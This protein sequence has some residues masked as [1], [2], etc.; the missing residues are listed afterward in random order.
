MNEIRNITALILA[1]GFGT[2]LQNV[3]DSRPKVL[4]PVAGRPF[5][6]FL[7]DQ[8][9]LAGFSHVVLCTGYKAENVEASFG[10]AY[11]SLSIRYS[12]ESEPLDTG[13]ALRLALPF[14]ETDFALVM[15]G[16]SYVDVRLCPHLKWCFERDRDA[17]LF[18]TRVPDTSRFGKV[19]ADANGLIINFEEK[20]KNQGTGWVNAGIYIL[21][22]SLLMS[23]PLGKPFSLEWEFFPSLVKKSLFGRKIDAKFIDIG[24]PDSYNMA[25]SFFGEMKS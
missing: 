18:L 21:K 6:T 11:K 5:L 23:M 19:I 3:V 2:R 25:E 16:D 14:I 12:H 13:G 9:I 1:G 8:L 4:A 24:T 7:L 22:K 10:Q 17:V 20:E 15:N